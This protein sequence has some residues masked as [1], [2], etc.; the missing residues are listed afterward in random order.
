MQKME[1]MRSSQTRMKQTKDHLT[2]KIKIM[3][4]IINSKCHQARNKEEDAKIEGL[5]HLEKD[6]RSEPFNRRETRI[7][8]RAK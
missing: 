7:S 3:Q 5:D 1:V 8:Q 6:L 4:V 2:K